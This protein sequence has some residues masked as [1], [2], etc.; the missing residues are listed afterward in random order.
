MLSGTSIS[1][2]TR[3]ISRCS[4]GILWY[5]ISESKYTVTNS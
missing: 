5:V 4:M 3:S 2:G 1:G